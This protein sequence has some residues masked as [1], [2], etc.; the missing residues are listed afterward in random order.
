MNFDVGGITAS[1]MPARLG[2]NRS[3]KWRRRVLM[4]RNRFCAKSATCCLGP[5][6]PSTLPTQMRVSAGGARRDSFSDFSASSIGAWWMASASANV[7]PTSGLSAVT[8]SS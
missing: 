1:A 7:M 6:T 4:R 5:I 3:P 8:V 2:L